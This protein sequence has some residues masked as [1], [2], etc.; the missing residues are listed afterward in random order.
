MGLG[1]VY[2]QYNPVSIAQIFSLRALLYNLD[3]YLACGNIP[4]NL[5]GKKKKTGAG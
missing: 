3:G 2:L 4:G 1:G 5:F